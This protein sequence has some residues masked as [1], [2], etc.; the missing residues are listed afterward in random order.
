MEIKTVRGTRDLLPDDLLLWQKIEQEF[1]RI[2]A[3]YGYEEIRTPVFE[4]TQLFVRGIGD[5]TDIVNKEM[6]SFEDRG[7]R[8]ITLRPEGTAGVVRAYLEH[9][10]GDGPA[11]E[12][13][14]Y[15]MGQMFRYERPQAGR[16]RQ[17]WQAGVE[18]IGFAD[19][20]SDAECIHLLF[21][22]VRAVGFKNVN[23]QLNSVG[24]PECRSVY[25]KELVSYL[26]D[27]KDFLSEDSQRRLQINPMRILDS[28]DESDKKICLQAPK[29]LDFLCDECSSHFASVNHYLKILKV[30]FEV[31]KMLVRGLDYYT[32]TAFE[33]VSADLGAQNAVAGGGRYDSMVGQLGKNDRPAVGFAI[34]MDRLIE[35]LKKGNVEISN[36]N[37]LSIA[38]IHR[39]EK[40]MERLLELSAEIREFNFCVKMALDPK[41]N[42]KQQFKQADKSKCRWA[43]VLGEEELAGD[44]IALKDLQSQEQIEI[45]LKDVSQWLKQFLVS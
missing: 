15:Y 45:N 28:K 9:Q 24:C 20:S 23:V 42:M 3:L 41:R 18:A 40:A 22:M 7:G 44:K 34:G 5:G 4:Q 14:L 13:K 1:R 29:V 43:F 36:R 19:P 21:S 31:N 6:Y 35:L 16:Y 10:M 12:R 11:G 26:N 17:F 33:V 32:R 27:Q 38:L 30:P 25:L 39:G 2:F 8:S 37:P